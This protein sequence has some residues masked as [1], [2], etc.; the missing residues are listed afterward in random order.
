ME[1]APEKPGAAG[2][3]R[4]YQPAGQLSPPDVASPVEHGIR[5]AALSKASRQSR[6]FHGLLLY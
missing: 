1:H 5:A 4:I 6:R 3:S 2:N